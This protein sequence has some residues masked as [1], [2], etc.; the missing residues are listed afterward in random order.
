[1]FKKLI[2]LIFVMSGFSVLAQ[3]TVF[4]KVLYDP[5]SSGVL[6][7]DVQVV[8]G[9]GYLIAGSRHDAAM[10][11]MVDTLGD[12]V[13]IRKSDRR[14]SYIS[15][16]AVRGDSVVFAAGNSVVACLGLD[17]SLHW[18]VELNE[19]YF[20]P[21]S[22]L[23]TSDTT[24]VIAGKFFSDASQKTEAY[25][26]E[27]SATGAIH[28]TKAYHTTN[29]STTFRSVKLAP[30]GGFLV[31]GATTDY[32]VPGATIGVFVTR[33]DRQGNVVR[34]SLYSREAGFFAMYNGYD[35]L[36]QNN[37]L[38][39]FMGLNDG[40]FLMQAD[41]LGNPSQTYLIDE[42]LG[43]NL[44]DIPGFSRLVQDAD[45]GFVAVRGGQF[46]GMVKTDS[47][48]MP[49]WMSALVLDA[50]TVAATPDGGYV[51]LGNGPLIGVDNLISWPHLG[52][53]KTDSTGNS[54]QCAYSWNQSPTLPVDIT[55]EGIG[56]TAELL[57]IT[58]G[59]G[60]A[61]VD[62]TIYSRQGCVDFVG[63]ITRSSTH[64]QSM[65]LAP[66]PANFSFSVISPDADLSHATLMEILNSM[67]Q[68]VFSLATPFSQQVT[69]GVS[70]FS[71]G[72]YLV[73]ITLPHEVVSAR[74]I[75]SH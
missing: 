60:P 26:M 43:W 48:G 10:L 73:R 34:T 29:N 65:F 4:D 39:V 7:T 25:L 58:A 44:F 46:G 71:P 20:D 69:F 5:N 42:T 15:A 32:S 35:L 51:V 8:A 55:M 31:V 36:V 11:C 24:F 2:S 49:Q 54:P 45:G 30:G 18:S 9:Q 66:N 57:E 40:L 38:M 50:K 52:M 1:M 70:T 28:W 62:S 67:G 61:F 64:R 37:R 74:L 41:T 53:I 33:L 16:M 21:Q 6:G 72:I 14:A 59:V 23:L 63:G 56:L 13:W 17:G 27:L 75:V 19:E 47:L 22:L 68:P 3:V 12:P